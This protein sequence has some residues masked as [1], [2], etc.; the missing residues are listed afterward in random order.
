VWRVGTT[1]GPSFGTHSDP[2]HM[3]NHP[4]ARAVLVLLVAG[5]HAAGAQTCLGTATFHRAPVRVSAGATF[6]DSTTLYGAGLALGAGAGPFA[7]A[8]VSRG[9]FEGLD[10]HA[11]VV[12]LAVGFAI[13]VH[14]TGGLQFC[15]RI[16]HRIQSGPDVA[17][18]LGTVSTSA[19]R[20]EVGAAF[21][22]ILSATPALDIVP[23]GDL[24]YTATRLTLDLPAGPVSNTEDGGLLEVGAGLVF[25]RRLTLRPSAVIPMG[26]ERGGSALRVVLAYNLG[27]GSSEP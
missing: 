15:P 9:T 26:G 18:G 1:R 6:A 22:G 8:M 2:I 12:D 25:R 19:R 14:P 21:G 10:D 13:D 4:L 23:F 16:G 24:A 3:T 17:A 20:I 5:A 7:S 27:F 11:T